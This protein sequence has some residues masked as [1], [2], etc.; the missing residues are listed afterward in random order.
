MLNLQAYEIEAMAMGRECRGRK[1]QEL[2]TSSHFKD[3]VD[4]VKFK[5]KIIK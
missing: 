4:V 2:P 3:L 5:T 1:L